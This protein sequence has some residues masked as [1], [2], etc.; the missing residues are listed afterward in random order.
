MSL[1]L[2]LSDAASHQELDAWSALELKEYKIRITNRAAKGMK[3]NLLGE[4]YAET[5][6]DE[7]R[8]TYE[9]GTNK[10]EERMLRRPDSP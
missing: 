6:I 5:A 8:K 1:C 4:G 3:R 10:N 7:K 9:G 2:T